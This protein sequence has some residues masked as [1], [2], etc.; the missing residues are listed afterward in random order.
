MDI[1]LFEDKDAWKSV[2][3]KDLITQLPNYFEF[4]GDID[5]SAYLNWRFDNFYGT[6]NDFYKMG[7]A[8]FEVAI[9]LIDDC[10]ANNSDKKADIWIFP[11]LFNVVHGIEIYLKGFNSQ[12]RILEKLKKNEY[13]DSKIEG[14]HNILQLCQQAISLIN[15]SSQKD[16][17]IEFKFVKRFIEILYEHTDDMTFARY[18]IAK[19]GESHFYVKQSKNITIDLDVLRVWVCKVFSILDCC[20]GFVDF[21]IDEIKEWLYEMQQEN[22]Y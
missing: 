3:T 9:Q 4:T 11:I 13:Q 16:L 20:T 17:L 1:D 5:H 6:E 15:Q 18:P 2:E 14:G 19:K 7:S 22:L 8:Y 10:L 12:I 21:Q